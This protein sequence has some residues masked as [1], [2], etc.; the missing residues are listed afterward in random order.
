MR[1]MPPPY[2]AHRYGNLQIFPRPTEAPAADKT[3]PI[4]PEKLPRLAF[5]NSILLH[6]AL[7]L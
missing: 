7:I 4:F 3:K 6:N 5:F 2:L 1:K